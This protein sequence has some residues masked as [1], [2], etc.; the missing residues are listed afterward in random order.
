MMD[1]Q[2]NHVS[3]MNAKIATFY[4]HMLAISCGLG[5]Y[6]FSTR[7]GDKRFWLAMGVCLLKNASQF[8]QKLRV[9]YPLVQLAMRVMEM[10]CLKQRLNL[11]HVATT[12]QKVDNRNIREIALIGHGASYF[13][14]ISISVSF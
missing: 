1:E 7:S 12:H 13:S 4:I 11:L 5:A 3:L 14:S 10:W 8:L 2:L 6:F 9:S